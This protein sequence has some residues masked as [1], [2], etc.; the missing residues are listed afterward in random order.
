[1]SFGRPAMM[2]RYCC[3]IVVRFRFRLVQSDELPRMAAAQAI[4]AREVVVLDLVEAVGDEVDDRRVLLA[5]G[6]GDEVR[7]QVPGL[8]ELSAGDVGAR[9]RLVLTAMS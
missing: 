4:A 3:W 6:E 1:M 5:D 2:T 8:G 7:A 9:G